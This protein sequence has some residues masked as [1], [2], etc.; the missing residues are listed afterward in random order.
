[1]LENKIKLNI[2][3][4]RKL[5]EN[6]NLERQIEKIFSAYKK[7][8]FLENFEIVALTLREKDLYKNEYLNLV[9]KIYPICKKYR[10]DLILH[11]NYNLNLD[12]KYKIEGIHLSYD[13][14]KSLNKNIREGLIKKYKRIGISIHSIDEAKEVE[15]LGATYVVAGHIFETDCKKDLEPRGLNFIKELSS[16]LTIP[17]F[18]IGGINEENSNLVLNSGAFGVCMMSSLMEY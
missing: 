7:K 10:I 3:T 5:C 6:E 15:N 17:I 9:K 4:N 11:Q 1:M 8:I 16:I 13:N 2:I 18:A 14:F 12:K